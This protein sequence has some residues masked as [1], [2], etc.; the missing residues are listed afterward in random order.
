MSPF[1]NWGTFTSNQWQEPRQKHKQQCL[2]CKITKTV[3]ILAAKCMF[4]KDPIAQCQKLIEKICFQGVLKSQPGDFICVCNI[5]ECKRRHFLFWTLHYQFRRHSTELRRSFSICGLLQ[6]HWTSCWC[7]T[8]QSAP[9]TR[10]ASTNCSASSWATLM[11][12]IENTQKP[13]KECCT[14]ACPVVQ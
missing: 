4:R 12:T 7:E 13:N 8:H 6:T 3:L 1:S 11:K 9:F 5:K 10:K 2:L 14:A